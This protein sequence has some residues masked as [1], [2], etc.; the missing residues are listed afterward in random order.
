MNQTI[1]ISGEAVEW[2]ELLNGAQTLSLEGAS[3]DGAW[4]LSGVLSWNIGLRQSAGE[5]DITLARKDG[6]GIFATLTKAVV[7]PV[8]ERD[9]EEADYTLHLEYEIDGG[10]GEFASAGGAMLAE[11]TLSR[12][13]FEARFTVTLRP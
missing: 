10:E 6:A 8:G 3:T 13:G 7:L 9:I 12:T 1:D 2:Q 11:G 5:G 4:S